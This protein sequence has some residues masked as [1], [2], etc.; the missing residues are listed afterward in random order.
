MKSPFESNV[1]G[2]FAFPSTPNLP[3]STPASTNF[4]MKSILLS[5]LLLCGAASGFAQAFSPTDTLR[6][7]N[8]V[9]LDA[10]AF[11][12]NIL[13][14][15]DASGPAY[16]P[17]YYI[18]Y[19]RY[20]GRG[21]LRAGIGGGFSSGDREE[22]AEQTGSADNMTEAKYETRQLEARLGYEFYTPLARRWQ[23]YYGADARVARGHS[24]SEELSVS[25]VT[26]T[27][28]TFES[29]L[30]SYGVA[31]LLG[32]RFRLTNRIS[33]RTETSF[34]INRTNQENTA[35]TRYS[36]PGTL[37]VNE[38]A[39]RSTVEGFSTSFQQPISVFINFDL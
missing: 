9:G 38:Q 31:P 27:E 39:I 17:T 37:P 26:E 12:K 35:R 20:I 33:L 11:I 18:T 36:I 5:I 22:A 32:V 14:F 10:T 2:D 15:D 3:S 4:S 25:G 19:R 30:S 7:R 29:H 6:Y 28:R 8:E 16:T 13:D 1:R 21:A 23:L 24:R 34:A